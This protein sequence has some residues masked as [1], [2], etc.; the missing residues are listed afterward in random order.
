M[1]GE[2]KGE[3]RG[4]GAA[5]AGDVGRR[6]ETGASEGAV[7]V[8]RV[9][10]GIFCLIWAVISFILG[11]DCGRGGCGE[12]SGREPKGRGGQLTEVIFELPGAEKINMIKFF[13][14][15]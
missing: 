9:A 5:G 14:C 1:M 15:F 11:T 13:A 10:G 4:G 8:E 3:M 6:R 12:C 2:R 7:G